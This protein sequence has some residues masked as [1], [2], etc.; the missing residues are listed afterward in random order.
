MTAQANGARDDA[1]LTGGAEV[2][3][4]YAEALLNVA[5]KQ[6][7]TDAMLEQLDSLVDDVFHEQPLLESL[8]A[9]RAVKREVK[10]QTIRT[11]FDHRADPTFVDFLLVLGR[12]GRLD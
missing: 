5:I 1:P 10:E 7:K 2:A 6:H 12:H 3:R 11:A 8:L 4:V 9:S